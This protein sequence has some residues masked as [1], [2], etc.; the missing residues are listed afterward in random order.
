VDW[1]RCH[2]PVARV[3]REEIDGGCPLADFWDLE[4]AA[5]SLYDDAETGDA[6]GLAKAAGLELRAEPNMPD[7]VDAMLVRN[8]I[9]FRPRAD[10]RRV[11]LAILH[12]IAH[13]LLRDTYHS[14]SDVWALTLALAAPL[15]LLRR[16][17]RAGQLTL[18]DLFWTV[19]A[20]AW[21][22]AARLEFLPI[23]L[24]A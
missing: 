13:W 21:S 6:K 2:D 18:K 14:H 15:S 11:L 10:G 7:G 5:N 23:D 1:R 20:P 24:A 9:L 12:E 17:K 22:L 16:L 8:I 3:A 19:L 4:C